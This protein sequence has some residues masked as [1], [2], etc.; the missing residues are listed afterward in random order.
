MI[1]LLQHLVQTRRSGRSRRCW[2]F[3]VDMKTP[4]LILLLLMAVVA[5][6]TEVIFI[7][8][9][10]GK[11]YEAVAST[12]AIKKTGGM[13][14][15]LQE[16]KNGSRRRY[17]S[18]PKG[19]PLTEAL[20]KAEVEAKRILGKDYTGTDGKWVLR[21]ATREEQGEDATDGYYYRFSYSTRE[22]A[23][24]NEEWL[25]PKG[26]LQVVVLLDG[27]LIETKRVEQLGAG[28]R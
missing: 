22:G 12:E 18:E 10:D 19:I 2:T 26:T 5:S 28:D 11:R 16:E 8:W 24:S 6:G 27:T 3:D 13:F 7:S 17:I 25:G 21:T 20:A 23:Y 4:I 14:P 9:V 1:S 15:C